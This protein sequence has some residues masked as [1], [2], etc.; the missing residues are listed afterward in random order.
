MISNY[1]HSALIMADMCDRLREF[2]IEA[3]ELN[4]AQLK[5]NTDPSVMMV[6][7]LS[8]VIGYDKSAVIS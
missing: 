5:E 7:A 2:M 8:P 6:T 1:L 3:T 4:G